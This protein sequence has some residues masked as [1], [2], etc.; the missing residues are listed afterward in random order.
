MCGI[1]GIFQYES[2]IDRAVRAR[3]LRIL[4]SDTMLLTE[5]RGDDATGIYQVHT[6]GDW[7]MAK[8]GQKVSK[9][10]YEVESEQDPVTYS[11]FM[12]TWDKHPKEMTALVGHCR[13]A[14]VG[15]R[16]QNNDDN[17]PFAIQLD[18]KNVILG[19]HNGTLSNHEII[20]KKLNSQLPRQGSVDSESIFHLMYEETE[21]GTQPITGDILRRMGER[22]DGAYAIIAVNTRFPHKIAV[23]R[24]GR[25]ADMMIISP[26]NIVIVASDRKFIEQ[27]IAKYDFY[28]RM[29]D[30]ELPPLVFADRMLPERDYRIFDTTRPFPDKVKL[31]W[32]DF[33]LVSDKGEMRKAGLNAVLEDW[34]APVTKSSSTVYSGGGYHAGGSYHHGGSAPYSA[35]KKEESAPTTEAGKVTGAAAASTLSGVR[36]LPASTIKKEEPL[37]ITAEVVPGEPSKKEAEKAFQQVASLG[38]CVSYDTIK[39]VADALGKTEGEVTSLPTTEL[40]T[41]LS[42]LHFNLGYAMGAI[43]GKTAIEEVRRLG[44]EQLQRMERFAEKQKKAEGHI[45]ELKTILQLSIALSQCGF[46][47][48]ERNVGIALSSFKSLPENRAKD[49]LSMLRSVLEDKG[50]Q[51]VIKDLVI[52]FKK[53]ATKKLEKKNQ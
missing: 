35:Y 24:E 46:P 27:A 18:E 19:V 23:F 16:G 48:S 14:T 44:R 15:S 40:A 12:S 3:A 22:I 50:A 36:A 49:V 25:P 53:S 31:E 9:F 45:W 30:Q 13:K 47:I 21:Q 1:V 39:E 33:D 26:L 2:K 51:K 10:L 41:A 4:F 11:D 37:T 52:K 6:D 17:H 20:F 7:M 28:R 5:P 32:N 34:R 29:I 43:D 42:K 8:K 38:L